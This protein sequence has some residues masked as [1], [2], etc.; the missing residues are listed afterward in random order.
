MQVN[1]NP[2]IMILCK[3]KIDK[4]NLLYELSI[5][6][7]YIH[8]SEQGLVHQ[9]DIQFPNYPRGARSLKDYLVLLHL[10]KY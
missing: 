8:L 3:G 6:N 1:I 4:F 5:R 9:F 10:H 7:K 2:K